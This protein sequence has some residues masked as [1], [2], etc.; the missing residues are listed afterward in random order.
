MSTGT[1][2]ARND[3]DPA[4]TWNLEA[5]YAT[6]DEY[7]AD[8]EK[9]KGQLEELKAF[10]GRLGEDAQTLATFMELYFELSDR[11]NRLAIYATLPVSV[12]QSNPDTHELAG[13]FQALASEAMTAVAFV[14]PELLAVG[15]EK[16]QGF[17]REE[18]RLAH[19]ERYFE[20]LEKGR[21]HVRSPEVEE[22]LGRLSDPFSAI[23]NAYNSLANGELPFEP[24][25]LEDGRE[26]EIAR[27]TYPQLRMSTDRELRRKAFES[28]SDGFLKFQ[29]TLTDLY[30]G[31][32]KQTI[33]S[34]RVRGYED[35][36]EEKLK[37]REVTREMLDAV[38]DT[39]R[40]NLGVWH[41]FWRARKAILGVE[42]LAEYDIFAPLSPNPPKVT[43][44]QAIQWMVEGM[45]PLG[46]EYVE[47]MRRGL[48]SERWV[49]VY[50]N[51]GKRDGAFAAS[52]YRTQPFIMMSYYDDLESVSTL[53]HELGHAMHNVLM[54]QVQPI[55][56][57]NYS[58]VV[59]ETASNFN[60]ALVRAWLMNEL[61][62]DDEQLAIIDEA[63]YNF[64]R[65]FFIMPT[66]VRFE[67]EVHSRLERGESLTAQHLNEIMRDLFQE[68][69]GD[70]IEAD[71]RTGITWAQFIHLYMPFYTFQYAV[72]ISAAAALS[73]DVLDGEEG[74]VERYLDF[75]RAGNAVPP[76]ELFRQAGVDMTTPEPIERA[77]KQLEGFVVQLEEIAAR[78]N[79]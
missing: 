5:L 75:L 62:S 38:V 30:L 17:M 39:F 78:R 70:E 66:L 16:L 65:Y 59:A 72:G 7:L 46:E 52:A 11:I 25:K 21:E 69:Y 37:P 23:E 12:D 2:P 54:N 32:V 50:P 3:L 71:E 55:A 45:K 44:E 28:Y 43:Y 29:N 67:L 8:Y 22:V 33:F 74:A 47:P 57:T 31:N 27:S 24:V 76:V 48:E 36:V 56:Y 15:S 64:H 58:M 9:A 13:H 77:F 61:T 4:F 73:Q 42:K 79:G 18:E 41:R 1:L 35:T 14:Q 51:R 10:Q 19:L 26:F 49:D 40:D 6:K 68:G 34:A 63:F 20:L 60:Q 53:A